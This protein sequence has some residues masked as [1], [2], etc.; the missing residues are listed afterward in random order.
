M[1]FSYVRVFHLTCFG[2]GW[3]QGLFFFHVNIQSSKK[4]DVRRSARDHVDVDSKHSKHLPPE[5]RAERL[6]LEDE[7]EAEAEDP[8][9]IMS[10]SGRAEVI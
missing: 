2:I 3:I 6:M 1:I 4:Q 10:P 9:S 5:V 7:D 8:I